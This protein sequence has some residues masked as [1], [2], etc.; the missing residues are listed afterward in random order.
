M[1]PLRFQLH[2]EL[3]FASYKGSMFHLPVKKTLNLKMFT[4]KASLLPSFLFQD[5]QTRNPQCWPRKETK[6]PTNFLA[7]IWPVSI[8]Y[9]LVLHG[10]YLL[11]PYVLAQWSH[12]CLL[13]TA[14]PNQDKIFLASTCGT[15]GLSL[16]FLRGNPSTETELI[17][18]VYSENWCDS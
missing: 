18:E 9:S 13:G 7:W 5:S 1:R 12:S 2:L 4:I 11:F 8:H 15:H 16:F 3:M 14:E 6:K 17:Q 10:N